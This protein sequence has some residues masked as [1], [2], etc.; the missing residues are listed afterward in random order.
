MRFFIYL[1]LFK[2]G[3]HEVLANGVEDLGEQWGQ[4]RVGHVEQSHPKVTSS[5][6]IQ[7][8]ACPVSLRFPLLLWVSRRT[9]PALAFHIP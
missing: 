2:P 6:G 9:V 3:S 8:H 5:T 4:V 7:R 1:F